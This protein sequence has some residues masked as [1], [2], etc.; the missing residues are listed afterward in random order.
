M[1]QHP[2]NMN[3]AV[4]MLSKCTLMLLLIEVESIS[5]PCAYLL[6]PKDQQ[7]MWFDRMIRCQILSTPPLDT[8]LESFPNTITSGPCD[9]NVMPLSV[10]DHERQFSNLE[11]DT[12]DVNVFCSEPLNTQYTAILLCVTHALSLISISMALFPHSMRTSSLA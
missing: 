12:C 6:L 7:A 10:I 3:K 5:K 4:Q 2:V 9:A 8:I 11:R 1:S